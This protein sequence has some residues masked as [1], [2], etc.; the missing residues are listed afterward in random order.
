MNFKKTLITLAASAM[1]L[2]MMTEPYFTSENTS[3][4]GNIASA[5]TSTASP[6]HTE[7]NSIDLSDSMFF[8][9][10]FHHPDNSID[11]PLPCFHI[12]KAVFI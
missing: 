8:P 7:E 2:S 9:P 12:R 5:A 11:I 1:S 3:F 10:V 4:T 6:V